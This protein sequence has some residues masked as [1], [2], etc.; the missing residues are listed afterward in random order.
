VGYII[1]ITD[2]ISYDCVV[3]VVTK[4]HAVHLRNQSVTGP[5]DFSLLCG[6]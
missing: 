3:S 6:V 4:L 2:S 5:K 1:T